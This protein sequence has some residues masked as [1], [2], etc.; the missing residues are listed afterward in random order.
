[1]LWNTDE[2]GRCDKIIE[3]ILSEKPDIIIL[4]YMPH[5]WDVSYSIEFV[6]LIQKRCPGVPVVYYSR[7]ELP[8]EKYP[9]VQGLVVKGKD[10]GSPF[11]QKTKEVLKME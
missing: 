2:E 10:F 4:D 6:R 9:E 7:A 3:A 8:M 5:L 1:M 11:L